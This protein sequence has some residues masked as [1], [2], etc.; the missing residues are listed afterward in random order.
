MRSLYRQTSFRVRS[1][2]KLSESVKE[3]LGVNQGGSASGNL[4]RKFLADLGNYIDRRFGIR[5]GDELLAH[6][7][8]ADDLVLFAESVRDAQNQLD[9]LF[10]FCASNLMVVNEIETKV[11]VV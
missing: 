9:G 4:F 7:L 1:N 8:W 3:L 2:G 11:I 5:I 10:K 6:L